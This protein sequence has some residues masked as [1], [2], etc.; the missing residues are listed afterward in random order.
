MNRISNEALDTAKVKTTTTTKKVEVSNKKSAPQSE[1]DQITKDTDKKGLIRGIWQAFFKKQTPTPSQEEQQNSDSLNSFT[2][3]HVTYDT[4]ITEA[5]AQQIWDAVMS[6]LDEYRKKENLLQINQSKAE[7]QLLQKE[8]EI[9]DKIRSMIKNLQTVEIARAHQ[10]SLD[11][12]MMAQRSILTILIIGLGGLFVSIVF[13]SLILHDITKSNYY[14][15]R[16]EASKKRAEKLAK[17]KEEFLANMSHE[18]RTPLSAIL[19]F[20]EQLLGS[21]LQEKHRFYLQAV[22][23]SSD[24]LLSTVNDIL[25]YSKI[26]AGQFTLE[27]VPF[28][29]TDEIREVCETLNLKASEK[30]IDLS[31]VVD[32]DLNYVVLGDAFRLKQILINLVGNAIKFTEEG[33]VRIIGTKIVKDTKNIWVKLAVEDSGIGISKDK[34]KSIFRDFSQADTTITRKYGGT[35]LGLA[36]TKK[37][38]LLH[39]GKIY[40][41]SEPGKGSVF[42]I[43]IKYTLGEEA[44]LIDTSQQQVVTARFDNKKVL[45]VDDDEYNLLLFHTILKKWGMKTDMASNG[46]EGMDL[47]KLK[48]YDLILSDIHMPEKSGMELVDETRKDTL[49]KN[50]P[51]LAITANVMKQDIDSYLKAGFDDFVLKPFKE[52]ELFQKISHAWK[53]KLSV[54]DKEDQEEQVNDSPLEN[55]EKATFSLFDIERFAEGDPKAMMAILRGLI[56]NNRMNIFQMHEFAAGKKWV[57]LGKV[58]H[59]MLPSYNHLKAFSVVS[60]LRKIED[61]INRKKGYNQITPLLEHIKTVSKDIFAALEE[62][63]HY[64]TNKENKEEEVKGV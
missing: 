15:S 35:G 9:M 56:D 37:L 40:V 18:I 28:R 38:I 14:K 22:K 33:Y 27:E 21:D 20:T 12:K 52:K 61:I 34:I 24:H 50:T 51:I 36:I 55:K 26:E 64:Y 54:E 30:N 45:V 44:S 2:E 32:E 41:D 19:G 47:I 57:E 29:I 5:D 63:I 13:I 46:K 62:R 11:S 58:A 42:T 53:I 7:F 49:N 16:L 60:A 17:A 39:N 25:D 43:E 6:V 23:N 4:V 8:A 48:E 31:Y 59:K 1:Q 10:N 3:T